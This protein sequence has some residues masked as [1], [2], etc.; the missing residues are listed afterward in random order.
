MGCHRRTASRRCRDRQAAVRRSG[1]RG[2]GPA[3]VIQPIR[4]LMSLRRSARFG[5]TGAF[6]LSYVLIVPVFLLGIMTI[7]QTSVWYLAKETVLA[8]A[9]QGADV[10]RTAQPP[11]GAG[12]ATAVE[13]VRSSANGWVKDVAASTS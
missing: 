11:P 2:R 7:V 12:A 9:R 5:E 8:A 10:A 6:T 1:E 3:E 13:F 4:R